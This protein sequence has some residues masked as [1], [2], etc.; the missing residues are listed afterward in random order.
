MYDRE[1]SYTCLDSMAKSLLRIAVDDCYKLT[2][3]ESRVM[4]DMDY[5]SILVKHPIVKSIEKAVFLKLLNNKRHYI[6]KK[7]GAVSGVVKSDTQ[8]ESQA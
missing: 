1:Q 2:G 6:S 3:G 4:L 7:K 5:R 8:V